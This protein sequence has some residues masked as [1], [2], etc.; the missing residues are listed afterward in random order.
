SPCGRHAAQAGID[1]RRQ[2]M[3]QAY[4]PVARRMTRNGASQRYRVRRS[5]VLRLMLIVIFVGAVIAFFALGGNEYLRLESV[6]RHRDTLQAFVTMHYAGA[7]LIAFVVY[8]AA[9]A[10]S[11]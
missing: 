2:R 3:G 5:V 8:A 6:K 1:A 10:F 9:T 4:L 11:L 7:L